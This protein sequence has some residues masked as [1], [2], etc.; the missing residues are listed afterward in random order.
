MKKYVNGEFIDLTE[1]EIKQ[2]QDL[3]NFSGGGKSW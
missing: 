1:D 3:E 2:I